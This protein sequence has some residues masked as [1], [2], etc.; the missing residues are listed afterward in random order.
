MLPLAVALMVGIVDFG[1]A[2][3][4]KAIAEKSMQNAARYLSTLPPAA[5]CDWGWT[6]AQN[7]AVTGKLEAVSSSN[8]PLVPNWTTNDVHRTSPTVCTGTLNMIDMYADV[9]YSPI[10][11]W[12]TKITMRAYHQERWIGQ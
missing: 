1:L 9:P 8:P 10:F 11:F 5:V 7:L 12:K 2:F 6:N 3:R 4:V